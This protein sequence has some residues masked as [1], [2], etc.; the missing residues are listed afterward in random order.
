MP[1]RSLVR[2]ADFR[3]RNAAVFV[4]YFS[5]FVLPLAVIL[6]VCVCVVISGVW[7]HVKNQ[8]I[9]LTFWVLGGL[10][11]ASYLRL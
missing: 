1:C 8:T 2:T 4:L 10:R 3:N 6:C 9:V 11:L 5:V 7:S